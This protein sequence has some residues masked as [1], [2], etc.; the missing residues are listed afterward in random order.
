[1]ARWTLLRR[2]RHST[3]GEDEKGM[4]DVLRKVGG[5]GYRRRKHALHGCNRRSCLRSALSHGK[6]KLARDSTLGGAAFPSLADDV[7]THTYSSARRLP[8]IG[9]VHARGRVGWASGSVSA[10]GSFGEGSG[11]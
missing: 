5:C 6:F 11:V 1:M 9:S 3:G 10:T 4:S 2:E 7:N 8:H